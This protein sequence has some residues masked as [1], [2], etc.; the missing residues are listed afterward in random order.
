MQIKL[1][2]EKKVEQTKKKKEGG[3]ASRCWCRDTVVKTKELTYHFYICI[4]SSRVGLGFFFLDSLGAGVNLCWG[5][6]L[7]ML[8]RQTRARKKKRCL[9]AEA[10]F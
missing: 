6:S 3:V 5:K 4:F 1:P 8:A 10:F 2:P 7:K 9:G